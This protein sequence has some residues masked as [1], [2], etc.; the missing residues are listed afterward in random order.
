MKSIQATILAMAVLT[1]A[2]A[3]AQSERPSI[4]SGEP[5]ISYRIGS[6]LHHSTWQLDPEL[7]PDTLLVD[8]EPGET[9][10]VCFI[11]DVEEF[12]RVTAIGE[13]YDFDVIHRGVAHQTRIEGRRH[14]PAVVFTDEY[15]AEHTGKITFVIPEVYELVNV[16]IALTEVAR[17]D[18]W[19]VYKHS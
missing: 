8:L 1:A 18:R 15:I 14:I 13:S 9:A 3:P 17:E 11:T 2:C 10:E 16:A 4:Q 5:V 6:D 19:L 12:C 7:Q